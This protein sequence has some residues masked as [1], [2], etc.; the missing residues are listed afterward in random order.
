MNALVN[1][2]VFNDERDLILAKWNQLQAFYGIGKIFYQ[3]ISIDVTK[4]TRLTRFKTIGYS[5]K[6]LYKNEDGLVSLI[7]N[8]KDTN[9]KTN[10]KNISDALFKIFNSDQSLIIK[11]DSIKQLSEDKTE[12]YLIFKIFF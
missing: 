2:Q 10:Q 12:V 5:C 3:N 4:D 11:I 9:V 6:P 7:I 8:Q 1:A